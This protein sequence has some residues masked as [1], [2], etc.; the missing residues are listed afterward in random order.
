MIQ[1]GNKHRRNPVKSRTTFLMHGSQNHQRIKL[2]DHYLRTTMSQYVHGCQYHTKA[3]EKRHTA[4]QL[5]FGS[6]LHVFSCQ[7]TVIRNIVMRQHHTFRESGCT[8]SILHIHNILTIDFGFCLIQ[9]LIAD[10]LTQE[11]QFWRIIHTTELLLT[12]IYHI[13]Q[14]RETFALQVTALRFLQFRKH[15]I[16]HVNIA[17]IEDT[18]CN[19][20]G[21]NICILNQKFQLVLLVIRID[22][23]RN[24]TNLGCRK[25]ECQPIRHIGSP[26][27]DMRAMFH[28]NGQHTF[29]HPVNPFVKLF[30]RKPK[31]TV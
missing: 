12:D 18:I 9:D 29:C 8:R 14:F 4:A 22:R 16:N 10:I 11:Q 5:I 20:H 17:A 26:N 7:E 23:N 21:M 1:F 31:I 28:S 2:L 30:P 25:Q 13:L 19:T 3:M 24:R 27:A 15:R 6:K